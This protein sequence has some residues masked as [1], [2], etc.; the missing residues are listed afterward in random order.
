MDK[1]GGGAGQRE[2]YPHGRR[3]RVGEG[4]L[5]KGGGFRLVAWSPCNMHLRLQRLI[6]SMPKKFDLPNR[7]RGDG[8]ERGKTG[9][10]GGNG[11]E[12]EGGREGFV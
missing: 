8:G 6:V 9:K 2:G 4:A 3:A 12:W 5:V 7:G 10:M 1:G 11:G